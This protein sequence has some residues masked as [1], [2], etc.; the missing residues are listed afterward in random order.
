MN[1][2]FLHRN[3]RKCAKYHCDKH[4]IKMILESCQ[5]MYTCH[6]TRSDGKPPPYIQLAPGGGYKPTHAKHPCSLWLLESLDNYRWLVQLTEELLTEY[7]FRYGSD[8]DHKCRAH[9]E[10]LSLVHPDGL[11]SSGLTPPRCAMPVEFKI[12]DDPVACYREYY[13]VGKV[14]ITSYKKRHKPHFLD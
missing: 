11:V 13:R 14:N 3:P 4:V 8:R 10:W 6:W 1:I 7:Q 9:L 2:F 12:S 5:L